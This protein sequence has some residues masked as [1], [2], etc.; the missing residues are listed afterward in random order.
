MSSLPAETATGQFTQRPQA[1][2]FTARLTVVHPPDLRAAHPGPGGV[3]GIGDEHHP[4]AAIDQLQE[5]V[6]IDAVV[7]LRRETH[8]RLAGPRADGVGAE[9]VLALDD[10]VARLQEGLV[11]QL[12]DLVRAAAEQQALGLEP[13]LF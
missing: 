6:D 13:V 10:V 2:T 5:L 8:L 3:A 9:A 1:R 12:E 11:D 7:L 4:G